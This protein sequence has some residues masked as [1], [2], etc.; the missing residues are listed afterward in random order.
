MLPGTLTLTC[1]PQ[2]HLGTG[3]CISLSMVFSVRRSDTKACHHCPAPIPSSALSHSPVSI[4]DVCYLQSS[5]ERV[6]T[7]ARKQQGTQGMVSGLND[8]GVLFPGRCGKNV[9]PNCNFHMGKIKSAS[10]APQP[11]NILLHC[12]WQLILTRLIFRF[13]PKAKQETNLFLRFFL[14]SLTHLQSLLST[15]L[16]GQKALCYQ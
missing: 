10:L 14:S 9:L 8:K 6:L 13:S 12:C 1:L 3:F 11:P 5:F 16:C 15:L 7:L 2:L 4:L